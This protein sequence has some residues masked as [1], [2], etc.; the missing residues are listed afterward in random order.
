LAIAKQ[1]P[2]S[3]IPLVKVEVA[4]PVCARLASEMLPVKV[5]VPAPVT[6]SAG[7]ESAPVDEME[8]VPVEPKAAV[9]ASVLAEKKEVEVPLVVVSPPLK[10]MRVVVALLV[11]GYANDA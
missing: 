2:A 5:E 6:V 10:A 8:V 11:N 3:V 4:D 7:V 9:L 1:P